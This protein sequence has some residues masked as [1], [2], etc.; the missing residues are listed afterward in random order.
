MKDYCKTHSPLHLSARNGHTSVI[1]ALLDAGMSVDVMVCYSL[2]LS[3]M[4]K[5]IIHTRA[6]LF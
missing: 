1:E 5:F 2:S 6:F 3:Q 4:F